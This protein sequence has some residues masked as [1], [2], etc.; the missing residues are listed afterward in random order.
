[1]IK[2]PEMVSWRYFLAKKEL[3]LP[4]YV[5]I[6]IGKLQNLPRLVS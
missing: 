2:T 1:M 3:N 4:D 5:D 6:I